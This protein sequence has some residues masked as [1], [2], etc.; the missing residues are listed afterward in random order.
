MTVCPDVWTVLPPPAELVDVPVT[1][2]VVLDAC[3]DHSEDV[4]PQWVHVLNVSARNVG[5]ARAAGFL[6]AAPTAEVT[7]DTDH[8]LAY[9][10]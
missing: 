7:L 3:T 8:V 6:A 1:V 5:A 10:G 2:M 4:I 9:T